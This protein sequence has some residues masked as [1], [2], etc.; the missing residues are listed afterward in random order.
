SVVTPTRPS[1]TTA[2]ARGRRP[3]GGIIGRL[4]AAALCLGFVLALHR[5]FVASP[6]GQRLDDSVADTATRYTLSEGIGNVF[7]AGVTVPILL[8]GVLLAV[9]IAL[10][11]RR[12]AEAVGVLVLMAGANLTTQ[13]LKHVL[14]ERP[15]LGVTL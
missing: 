1:A 2:P 3:W 4:F 6:P 10:L 12:P 7:L 5:I 8:G 9:L 15:D 13:A 11:R 14:L